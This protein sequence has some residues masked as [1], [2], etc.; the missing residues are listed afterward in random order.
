MGIFNSVFGGNASENKSKSGLPWQQLTTVEQLDEII[1]L[2][3]TKPVAIFKH[4]T[5]C[6]ISRMAL[7]S[8]ESEYDIESSELDLYF[9]DLKAYRAVS[10]E[11]A[12]R[13]EVEHQSPQLILIKN[14]TAVYH[15]SHGSISAA[16]LKS[17]I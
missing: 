10:N 14:G 11:I 4:S 1:E 5:T 13:F 2:S 3:K 7:R 16:T 15:D 6:G 8:F 17:K 12:N 9:L